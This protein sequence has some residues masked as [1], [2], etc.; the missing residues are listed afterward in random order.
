KLLHEVLEYRTRYI[1]VVVEDV[2]QSHN[3]SAII[4][5]CEIF[6]VQDIHLIQKR[7]RFIITKGVSMG[8]AKWMT[9]HRHETVTACIEALHADGYMI[10]ATTPS[11]PAISMYSMTVDK[12]I[13]LLF[14]GERQ[15]LSREAL[16]QADGFM[17]IPM[18]GFTQ[19]FNVSVSVALCLQ[20]FVP[21]IH[22][23]PKN[24]WNVTEQEKADIMLT[25]MSRMLKVEPWADKE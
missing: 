15:G 7:N 16:S 25:W 23:L 17:I 19:S 24:K 5:S 8:A 18:Y 9:I 14:G 11:S 10:Y 3:A 12:K 20:F 6:G 2:H 21:K 1:T 4:R 22:A 13:A